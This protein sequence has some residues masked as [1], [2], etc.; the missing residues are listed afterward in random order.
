[1]RWLA[2]SLTLA[3]SPALAHDPYSGIRNPRG[4]VCCNNGDCR[5]VDPAEI[6][7]SGEYYTWRGGTFPKALSQPSPIPGD[8]YHVCAYPI[9]HLG[10]KTEW[11]IRCILR[12][13]AGV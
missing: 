9:H 4:D 11:R 7:E 2:L 10:G 13:E 12:P 1:M 8:K 6:G 3:A 5:P